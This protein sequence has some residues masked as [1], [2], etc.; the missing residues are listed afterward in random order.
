MPVNAIPV[1]RRFN[2]EAKK[3]PTPPPIIDITNGLTNRNVTPKT[4][5]SVIPSAAES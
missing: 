4:A 1:A 2:S 3:P 5:G